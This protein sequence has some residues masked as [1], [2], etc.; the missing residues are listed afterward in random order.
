MMKVSEFIKFRDDGYTMIPLEESEWQFIHDVLVDYLDRHVI[1]H[2]YRSKCES[3]LEVL[4][5]Y[6]GGS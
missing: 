4:H 6:G 3:I 5:N 1:G 2:E